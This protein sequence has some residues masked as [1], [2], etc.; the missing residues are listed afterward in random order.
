MGHSPLGWAAIN[1]TKPTN[2][3]AVSL[4]MVSM[5]NGFDVWGVWGVLYLCGGEDDLQ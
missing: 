2:S 1:Y 5:E 4:L 3:T